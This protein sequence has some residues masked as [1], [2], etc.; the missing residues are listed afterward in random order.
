MPSSALAFRLVLLV[1]A[2]AALAGMA[3]SVALGARP[4]LALTVAA[5][6]A[7]GAFGAVSGWLDRRLAR[8][9]AELVASAGQLADGHY[10]LPIEPPVD[11]HLASLARAL[12]KL[13]RRVREEIDGAQ[14]ERDQLRTI[15]ARMSEGVLVVGPDGRAVLANPAFRHLFALE[16]EVAGRGPMEISRQP[17]LSRLIEGTLGAGRSDPVELELDLPTRRNLSL[18]SASLGPG[19]GAVV[20]AR[21]TTAFARLAKVRRDFV[22]NV[23]HELKTPLSA[24]RGYA[25]TLRDGA[26]EEPATA[27]RFTERILAQCRRLQALLDDLLTLSRLESV[28]GAALPL[29]RLDLA[30]VVQRAVEVVAEPAREK[31]VEIAVSR[32]DPPIVMGHPASLERLAVN[33]LDNAVKYNRA[34]GRVRVHLAADAAQLLLEVADTGIGIPPEAL[35][36]IFERFYRVDKGRAREEGGTG[37]GLAIVKHI[38]QLHG[39]RIEVESEERRGSTFRVYLPAARGQ[40]SPHPS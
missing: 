1:P 5:G 30:A 36:R 10:D 39:G 21:D 20:V 38:A 14:A 6:A 15:L 35:P 11:D 12:G 34:G 18:A 28:D 7:L 40:G 27:Q 26:L 16:G 31:G 25:E 8:P 24:I 4:L 23:S 29:E 9:F 2:L 3:I 17:Q 19:A 32:A 37:L 22:A 33:L 13:G